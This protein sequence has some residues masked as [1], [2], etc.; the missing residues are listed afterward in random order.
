MRLNVVWL[1]GISSARP[2][3]PLT[4]H[5]EAKRSAERRDARRLIQ[6]AHSPTN[7][8]TRAPTIQVTATGF[9]SP[10]RNHVP[11]KW[12]YDRVSDHRCIPRSS[13]RLEV[14]GAP[15]VEWRGGGGGNQVALSGLLL[16]WPATMPPTDLNFDANRNPPSEEQ[17]W[18]VLSVWPR[19]WRTH[20]PHTHPDPHQRCRSRS[21]DLDETEH[22]A[23]SDGIYTVFQLLLNDACLSDGDFLSTGISTRVF[24]YE[25]A[26][27]EAFLI[28]EVW[29]H[30]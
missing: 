4:G 5:R 20:P 27:T 30:V 25:F 2:R 14:W 8:R 17:F 6:K 12:N 26:S 10:F 3:K 29:M 1:T 16:E 19:S 23:H 13:P 18:P 21:C 24:R 11:M 9:R 7:P 28:G 15:I 22:K